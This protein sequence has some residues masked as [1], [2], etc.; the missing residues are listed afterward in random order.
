MH[1]TAGLTGYIRLSG[2]RLS[3]KWTMDWGI[4]LGL[5]VRYSPLVRSI[6][7]YNANNIVDLK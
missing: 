1:Q 3:D 7:K 5:G 6:I 4:G 2:N